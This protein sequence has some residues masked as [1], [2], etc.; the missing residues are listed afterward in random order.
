[1]VAKERD[2]IN[3]L[4]EVADGPASTN[5]DKL[6]WQIAYEFSGHEGATTD[7]YSQEFDTLCERLG[8]DSEEMQLLVA[9]KIDKV[10]YPP[11]AAFARAVA[12]AKIKP[13]KFAVPFTKKSFFMANLIYYLSQEHPCPGIFRFLSIRS[14]RWLK[15]NR[16]W[17]MRSSMF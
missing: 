14:R 2:L 4:A 17:S 7:E 10:Q 5:E 3:Y 13:K 11:G 15:L 6:A 9:S 1:M 8:F 16:P 12:N